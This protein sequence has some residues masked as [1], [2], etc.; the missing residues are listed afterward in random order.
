MAERRACRGAATVD[1]RMG[2]EHA[3]QCVVCHQKVRDDMVDHPF[4]GFASSGCD[5]ADGPTE[6]LPLRGCAHQERPDSSTHPK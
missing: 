1:A 4:F 3:R 5:V 2:M 6:A